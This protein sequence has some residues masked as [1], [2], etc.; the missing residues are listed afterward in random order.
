[1]PMPMKPTPVKY[2]PAC[3]ARMLRKVN[4]GRTEDLAAFV[5]RKYCNR[6]CMAQAMV[7][8]QVTVGGYRKRH[9]AIQKATTCAAC[10]SRTN[11]HL[12]H[13]NG[14]ISDNSPT[15]LETL[16]A[17]CHIKGHWAAKR[18]IPKPPKPCIICG[19][20]SAKL[21]RGMCQMHYQRWKRHGNPSLRMRK[22]GS[23]WVLTDESLPRQL[24][25]SDLQPLETP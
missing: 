11:L 20:L 12:H 2:C 15:N 17:S 14:D 3:N 5:K 24:E 6:A 16:C 25:S 4:R 22:V 8:E 10:G 21:W 7:K 23:S 18:R 1:M 19:S 9:M 13:R